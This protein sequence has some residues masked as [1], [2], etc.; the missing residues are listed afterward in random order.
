MSDD[1]DDGAADDEAGH[2]GT[3][4]TGWRALAD[5]LVAA[6][7]TE[8]VLVSLAALAMSVA[9]GWVIVFVSGALTGCETVRYAIG[10]A[11]SCY[12][13]TTTYEE[14]FLSPFRNDFRLAVLGRETVILL[15]TGLSV[16]VAFR[17]GLFNIGTQG[18][19]VVGA[20]TTAVVVLWVGDLAPGGLVGTAVMIPAGLVSGAVAGGLFGAIPGALKAYADANEVITTIML[21]FV[22]ANVA[23]VAV[24]ERFQDPTTQITRTRPIP[25]NAEFPI[26]PG[27]GLGQ[28]E[29]FSLVA[30][31]VGLLLVAALYYLLTRTTL[32]YDLRASGHQPQAAEYGGVPSKRTVVKS[33][34]ISGGLGGLGGAVWVL[35]VTTYYQTGVPAYGFDGITVSILVGNN[36]LGVGAAAFLF[37]LLKAGSQ[38]VGFNTPVPKELVGVLRGLIIL[39]VAMPEFFRMGWRRFGDPRVPR[40]NEPPPDDDAVDDDQGAATSTDGGRPVDV[41]R[42]GSP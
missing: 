25:T 5:R 34:A 33:M 31:L 30:A 22:A 12:N 24:Q 19:L 20:F 29:D 18:Q 16:A 26:L 14:L 1:T 3:E 2:D 39:F 38:S 35:M 17:A 15:F 11:T 6:S 36:P 23:L 40:R 10:P 8:R 27:V 28:G 32:G 37:G 7:A 9:V 42:E 13:P 4:R 41:D 21:N